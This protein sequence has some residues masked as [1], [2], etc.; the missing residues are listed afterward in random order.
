MGLARD[1]DRT[2]SHHSRDVPKMLPHGTFM[3]AN[4][5]WAHL[6]NSNGLFSVEIRSMQKPDFAVL[7]LSLFVQSREG[8]NARHK[9]TVFL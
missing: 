5:V 7:A 2:Q 8:N 9:E 4:T 1:S 3:G 6:S